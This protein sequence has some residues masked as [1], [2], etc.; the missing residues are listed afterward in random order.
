MITRQTMG[1]LRLAR[2]A[3]APTV[4]IMFVSTGTVVWHHYEPD[5]AI[6]I[7]VPAMLGTA[8]SILLGFRTNAAYDRWWEARKIW[9]AIVNDSRTLARQALTLIRDRGLAADL[10]HRQ[11]AWNY[12]FGN[13]LRGLDPFEPIAGMLPDSEIAT[14][15]EA[16]NPTNAMLLT[17]GER[18]EAAREA[19]DLESILSLELENTLQRLT[20]HMGMA[21][22][23]NTTVF[24]TQYSIIL[25]RILW[26]FV[27]L[28]PV[29]LVHHLG[30][31]TVVVTLAV[32]E[33]FVF[34]ELLARFLQDPFCNRSTDTPVT[35]IAR[36]IEINLREMLDEPEIPDA[37]TSIDGVLM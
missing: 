2:H 19:G 7:A 13:S 27:L 1:W 36:T 35:A 14:L 4:V 26:V 16:A 9:G 30:W 33:V 6:D 5:F 28:L 8:L 34:I 20:D 17:Q 11:I 12:A 23:I 25:K 37:L 29:G 3:W 31:A 21:E 24:P 15:R 32:G 22:R 10:I 18:L